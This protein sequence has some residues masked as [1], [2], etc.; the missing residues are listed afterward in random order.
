[1]LILEL[2]STIFSD[3][4]FI[5]KNESN[6]EKKNVIGIKSINSELDPSLFANLIKYL[7]NN[8]EKTENVSPVRK[9]AKSLFFKL[10]PKNIKKYSNIFL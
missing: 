8:N 2:S 3:L 9:W 5:N 10:I 1:L 4:I 7:M 6:S